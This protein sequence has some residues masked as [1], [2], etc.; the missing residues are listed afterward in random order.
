MLLDYAP[1]IFA[2]MFFITIVLLYIGVMQLFRTLSDRRVLAERIHATG[3]QGVIE[4][5]LPV[6]EKRQNIWSRWL[7]FLGQKVA[8]RKLEDQVILRPKFLKAGLRSEFT[9]AVF[10]GAKVLLTLILPMVFVIFRL[11][12]PQF[13]ISA[14]WE[15]I[16][17]VALPLT[18]FHIPDLWLLNKIQKRRETILN[19]FPDALDLLVVCVQAGMGLD[20]AINRVSREIRFNSPALSQELSLFNLEIRAGLPRR[21]A[22]NNL[23]MRTDLQEMQNLVTLLLQTDKFGTSVTQ[24]LELYAE[25]MRMQRMQRAEAKAARIPVKLLFPMILLIFPTMFI[26]ILGPAIIQIYQTLIRM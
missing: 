20:A 9:P 19:G 21:N 2:A 16:L 8:H 25:T 10:W 6:T 14:L 23:A 22:L 7:T 26:A 24:A 13:S 1:L 12:F 5:G 15:I 11:L 3:G 4:T 18:G 17:F